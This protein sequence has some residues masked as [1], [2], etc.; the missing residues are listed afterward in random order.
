MKKIKAT[1]FL[2][3]TS[4]L[5]HAQ[6]D[7][8][9]EY[10]VPIIKKH[11]YADYKG[12]FKEPGG[13]LQYPFI[14]PGSDQYADVLWDWDSWLT[15]VAIR[16]ILLDKGS[17]S[18]RKEAL[19]Y[20]RGCVL[21]YLSFGGMNGWIPF[22][23]PRNSGSRVER[24]EKVIEE[25]GGLYESNMHKPCLAQHAAFLVKQDN[26]N[27]E[28]LREKFYFLQAFVNAYQNHYKNNET[29]LCFWANDVSIGVDTDPSTFYRPDKSSGSIFLNTLLYKEL[30][31]MEYLANTLNL[32]EIAS[33]YKKDA[34]D[35]LQS[36][37]THC[38]DER[39]GFYYSVDLNMSDYHAPK[40]W[41][42]LHIGG[43]KKW[44]CVIERLDVWSGFM[45]LWGKIAT[46]EQAERIV[47]EHYLD[48][49]R[50]N[51]PYGVRTLSPLEKMYDVRASGN[52]SSWL[53]PI[54][55][56]SNYLTF[57]GLLNYNYNDEAKEMATETI[58]MFGRDIEENGA[59]HEYY[60]PESGQPVLNKGFKNW[61]Y[62]V[63]NMIIWLEGGEVV[64]EF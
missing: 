41:Q 43:A 40:G 58:K 34:E 44:D 12:M 47:K 17:K 23:I 38:W 45:P 59:M 4:F 63:L 48:K 55:G 10:Y 52:P 1:V 33:F 19:K 29:G 54:W 31:A 6:S 28:W 14:T 32:S 60:L 50:F 24:M 22:Y 7:K 13:V 46:P 8:D 16:Q 25:Y 62:L 9:W 26:G 30:K 61:N 5:L 64:S 51:S 56:V 11:I 53:G 3:I 35:L 49:K 2:I 27:A 18:E 37:R 57:K 15:N 21:N 39:D 36:I 20:E 42:D